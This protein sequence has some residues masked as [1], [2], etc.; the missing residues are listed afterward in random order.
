[1]SAVTGHIGKPVV[2]GDSVGFSPLRPVKGE[3][4]SPKDARSVNGSA[5]GLGSA[6][7]SRDPLTLTWID[8]Y[9]A[10]PA[11]AVVRNSIAL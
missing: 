4:T 8:V 6:R 9:G 3:N 2:R 11:C 5:E 10:A 7:D 1:M